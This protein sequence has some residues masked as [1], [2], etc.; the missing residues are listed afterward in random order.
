MEG[1]N[2]IL[3]INSFEALFDLIDN[4]IVPVFNAWWWIIPPFFLFRYVP[5]FWLL[6]RQSLEIKKREYVMLEIKLPTEILKPVRAMEDVMA[7]LFLVIVD[8][9]PGCIREKWIDGDNTLY[10]HLSFEIASFG[11]QTKFFVRVNAPYRDVVESAIYAQYPEV[12]IEEAEDYTDFVPQDIPNRG[13]DLENREWVLRKPSPYPIM[14][15][16]KLE[17][18][19]E[20][21]EEKRVDSMAR[22]LE[23]LSTIKEGE[24][25]WFQIIVTL[26]KED[27][28]KQGEEIRDKLVF[29]PGKAPEP[30][31]MILQAA[32]VLIFGV[33]EEKEE[34]KEQLLPPEMKMTPG[35]RE[36]VKE[37]E[38]KIAKSGFETTIRIFYLA[39]REVWFKPHLGL[40]IAFLT[41]HNTQDL[42][43]FG[44]FKPTTSKVK[45]PF[46][47]LDRRRQFL[48][49]RRAFRNYKMRVNPLFPNLGGTSVLNAEELATL[50]HFPSR[51]MAPAPFVER[52]E[53][54]RGEA[55]SGLPI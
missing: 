39:K 52:I 18:E 28:V 29:R 55:P 46:K 45:T 19:H 15:Y 40:P 23:A 54:K 35:E 31:P 30:K 36:I 48:R 49:K 38:A 47:I 42:N 4:V 11:G 44:V 27:L 12:Q 20:S 53:H 3:L 10:P 13:W 24:Q 22:L 25:V 41:S 14:T 5:K 6:W 2:L 34:K 37:I 26:P 9:E 17:T 33:T 50:F 32:D 21:K 43:S 7:A 51:I 16:K 8:P 1:D